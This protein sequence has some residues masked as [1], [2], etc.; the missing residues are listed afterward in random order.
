MIIGV[1][2]QTV[3]LI[4]IT[5][6]TNWNAEVIIQSCLMKSRVIL[7]HNNNFLFIYFG[8]TVTVPHAIAGFQSYWPLK[9]I[10]KRIDFRTLG[11]R[12]MKFFLPAILGGVLSSVPRGIFFCTFAVS[13]PLK[14]FLCP[15][16]T[17]VLDI[18]SVQWKNEV[19][20]LW[21]YITSLLSFPPKFFV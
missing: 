11:Q 15:F 14:F 10:C 6:R 8:H 9:D 20:S 19:W 13:S 16:F 1:I 2:L 3:T 17:P 21:H 5:A 4:F 12:M 7:N 18:F